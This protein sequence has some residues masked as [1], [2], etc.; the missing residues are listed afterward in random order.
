MH[1][2]GRRH[3]DRDMPAAGHGTGRRRGHDRRR[4]GQ[5]RPAPGPACLHGV[6]RPAVR[7][8]HP[9]V[10]GRRR[11]LRRPLARC[12][13][14]GRTR[15]GRGR[16]GTRRASVPLRGVRRHPPGRRRRMPRRLRRTDRGGAGARRGR[17]QG[18]RRR[19]LHD[20]RVAAGHAARRA[21]ALTRG[22]GHAPPP[23]PGVGACHRRR[24]GGRRPAAIGP[25]GPLGRPAARGRRGR[26]R[27]D[28]ASGGAGGGAR[29]HAAA[30]GGRRRRRG[31]PTARRS[32][33]PTGRRGGRLPTHRRVSRSRSRGVATGAVPD[34]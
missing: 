22:G 18:H 32:S 27:V 28:G 26:R 19:P 4:V 3:P 1:R 31:S 11:G 9:R 30:G 10:R 8:L 23:R 34:W 33:T 16:R 21:R 6:R 17:G 14:H 2:P 13:R 25:T 15:P 24:A 29:H 5:R 20:G 7:V 12:A